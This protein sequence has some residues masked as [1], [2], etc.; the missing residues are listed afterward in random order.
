MPTIAA[1]IKQATENESGYVT[2]E[3]KDGKTVYKWSF[4]AERYLIDFADDYHE[5]GLIQ[6]D[7][8][9]DAPYFGVWISPS[10]MLSLTYCEGDWSLVICDNPISFNSEVDSIVEGYEE[11][12]GFVSVDN[13]EKTITEHYQQKA[14]LYLITIPHQQLSLD[15]PSKRV[16]YEI[17]AH[18][19]WEMLGCVPPIVQSPDGFMSSEPTINNGEEDVYFTCL[20]K[21]NRYW[22]ILA[23]LSEWVKLP[24]LLN[25]QLSELPQ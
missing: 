9:Q 15:Y 2:V 6:Y 25:K 22:A 24:E 4:D 21:E 11:A 5:H 3:Q 23:T 8:N 14:E 16:F 1:L 12:P 10:K 17:S 19:Y 7:T 20:E 13:E 18:D